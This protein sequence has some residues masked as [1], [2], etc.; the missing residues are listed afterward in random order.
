MY[1]YLILVALL[2][3]H[4]S[5]HQLTPTYPEWERSFVPRVIQTKMKLFNKRTD[6]EYFEFKVFDDD[7]NQIPFATSEKVLRVKYLENKEVT[8]Y[9]REEDEPFARYICSKSKILSGNTDQI[10]TVSS[11]ICSKIK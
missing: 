10:T 1:R 2:S 7:W 5:A 9:L 6:V 4:V 11:R 8:I 3:G